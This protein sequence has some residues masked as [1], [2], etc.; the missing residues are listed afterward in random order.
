MRVARDHAHVLAPED[1]HQVEEL[2]AH[3]R[4]DGRRVV[5]SA[6]G[7]H[8]HEAQP[9]GHERLAGARRSA[10]H[11]V[12]AHHE[13]HE[14]LFLMRPELDAALGR[15]REEAVE[16]LVGR[17]PRLR[18]GSVLGLPPRRRQ[19][20][21]R[22]VRERIPAALF[23]RK[24]IV[25]ARAAHRCLLCCLFRHEEGL[26]DTLIASST[27]Y[28]T[29]TYRGPPRAAVKEHARR[30]PATRND[31]QPDIRLQRQDAPAVG[32]RA[33]SGARAPPARDANME[34][35][36]HAESRAALPSCPRSACPHVRTSRTAGLPC[37]HA[38]C[39]YNRPSREIP[40]AR[41]ARHEEEGRL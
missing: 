14:G 12:V 17:R 7:R 37:P 32:A 31:P 28:S 30:P 39:C 33:A 13:R 6:P 41:G 19:P 9:Q 2:L 15:P 10:Q 36:P 11:H 20:S 23:D 24:R 5:R 29:R 18:L 3:E 35:E 26:R 21:E 40:G 25:I 1:V 27:A 38:A 16:R 34:G 4:L 22:S 8:R